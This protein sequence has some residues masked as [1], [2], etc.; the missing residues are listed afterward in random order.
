MTYSRSRSSPLPFLWQL[1]R[2]CAAMLMLGLVATTPALADA[3]LNRE[4]ALAALNHAEPQR[5]LEAM[6]RLADI[7]TA[8]DASALVPRLSD[9][10]PT[11]RQA[12]VAFIWQLWGHSGDTE[13]DTLYQQGVTWM[14]TGDLSKAVKVF[15]DI[16][17][18]RPAFAEAWNKRATVYYMMDEYASSMRDCD[19]VLARVP[20]HFGALSGYAQML[21]ERGEP[22]RALVYL[23]RAYKI[24]PTMVNAEGMIESLRRQIER[25]RR[26]ST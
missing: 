4:Q 17:D 14:R 21:T 24:N 3:P 13:I 2:S 9:A 15:S 25:K 1:I 22:E 19:A 8:A 16:I 11:L 20:Y 5:R 26:N 12:A 7:G 6:I 23:E 18:Q 10:D